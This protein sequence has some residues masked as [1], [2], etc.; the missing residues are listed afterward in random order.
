MFEEIDDCNGLL[1]AK[2]IE[3]NNKQ[4]HAN[5]TRRIKLISGYD[6]LTDFNVCVQECW[7]TSSGAKILEEINF[8]FPKL[9]L[10]GHQ[11]T[12]GYAVLNK[13]NVKALIGSECIRR[14]D[15]PLIKSYSNKI[16]GYC[17]IC[18]NKY[19]D[20][21]KHNNNKHLGETNNKSMKSINQFLIKKQKLIDQSKLIIQCKTCKCL[22]KT[23]KF[24]SDT[25][26]NCYKLK[27]SLNECVNCGDH[28]YVLK[29]EMSWRIKCKPCYNQR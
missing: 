20:I 6:L 3:T 26:V 14:I 17:S 1:C 2:T 29:E 19:K 16:P 5:L 13:N 15:K 27:S 22:Y 24:W 7:S 10:C 9:C 8:K 11:I 23:D 28:F 25:C 18:A 12:T 4:C 21:N